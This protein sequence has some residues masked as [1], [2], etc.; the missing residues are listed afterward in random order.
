[1]TTSHSFRIRSFV[2]RDSRKT[3]SQAKA[4]ID[5]WP[6]YGLDWQ[7]SSINFN[8]AFGNRLPCFLEIGFGTGQTL[9]AAAQAFPEFN[10]IGVETYRPGI[11]ALLLGIEHHQLTNLKVIYGDIVDILEKGIPDQS[12]AGIQI[13]FPDPWQKR[14][15]HT[16]RLIQTHFL[17]LLLPKLIENG[18]LHL[19]TDWDDYAQHMYKVLSATPGIQNQ[20]H[21]FAPRSPFRPILS[22]FEQRALRDGRA[23]KDLQFVAD[24][25]L[26]F[27]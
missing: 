19:A 8:H 16:R 7:E 20:C 6:R 17:Q 13:F 3:P 15:H 4:L 21:Q 12:L 27:G 22:K 24:K 11:G 2:R 26:R 9:L 23:V 10:F 1:M 18:S 5:L 14:R 25:N